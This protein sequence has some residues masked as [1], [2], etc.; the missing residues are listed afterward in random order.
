VKKPRILIAEDEVHLREIL[1]FQLEAAGFEVTQTSDGQEAIDS[2]L[3]APPDLALLDVMMPNVDGY[4][5][6]RRLRASFRTRHVPIIMLTAKTETGDKVNGLEGG[7]NDYVTK[8]WAQA[9][10]VARA[11]NVLEWSRMQRSASPLTGLPGNLSIDEEI[12]M[13]LESGKGFAM[14]QVDVDFFKSFNDKYGYLRGDEAIQAVAQILV[15]TTRDLGGDDAF[16]GHIGGDDFVILSSPD[17]AEE[18]GEEVI[19]R[20]NE[21]VSSLY[22]EADRKRGYVEVPNRRHHIERF[23]FMSLTMALVN[24]ERIPVTHQAELSDIAQ[25]LKAHGKS[26]QGSVLVGE[27]RGE[28]LVNESGSKPDNPNQSAA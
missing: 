6:C 23:P 5:V 27:R 11:R 7:A 22:D 12:R 21:K 9:E 20:F 15:E 8:P 14:I 4:E 18:I 28:P 16:V 25:E 17:C 13:R 26:I 10:L 1:R 3:N 19:L 2:A 24:T